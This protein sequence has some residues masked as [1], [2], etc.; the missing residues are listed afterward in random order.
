[1]VERDSAMESAKP[2]VQQDVLKVKARQHVRNR[3]HCHAKLAVLHMLVLLAG[4]AHL[5]AT[6]MAF[7]TGLRDISRPLQSQLQ[8]ARL[9][10]VAQRSLKFREQILYARL[11]KILNT[12][13]DNKYTD[14][15][16]LPDSW[17]ELS[18]SASLWFRLSVCRHSK[19]NH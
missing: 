18:R 7:S 16:K 10:A 3:L 14:I 6:F 17:A 11:D 12:Q 5:I 15:R 1:M 19:S 2:D 8:V 9:E 13:L 4:L